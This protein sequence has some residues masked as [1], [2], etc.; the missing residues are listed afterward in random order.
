M[1][2]YF[3]HILIIA[4]KYGLI[5]IQITST[6]YLFHK[7]VVQNVCNARSLDH[8]SQM[9]H[10]LDI[11]KIYDLIDINTCI[12]MFNVLHKLVPFTLLNKFS[13]SSCNKYKNNFYV[14]L[15]LQEQE[16]RNFQ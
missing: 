16:E 12:L 15:C 2:Q 1:M 7:S 9:L 5:L 3:N 8:T 11:L 14:M 4:L 13:M 10:Q 6:Q